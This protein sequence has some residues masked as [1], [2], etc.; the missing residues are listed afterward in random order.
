[1]PRAGWSSRSRSLSSRREWCGRVLRQLVVP[2]L[3]PSLPPSLFSPHSLSPTLSSLVEAAAAGAG[4]STAST[5]AH[6]PRLPVWLGSAQWLA[7]CA[8]SPH[9][10]DRGPRRRTTPCTESVARPKVMCARPCPS[11]PP[12]PLPDSLLLLLPRVHAAAAASF[13]NAAGSA[14]FC[15]YCSPPGPAGAGTPDPA[16][17]PWPV[18][19]LHA[20]MWSVASWRRCRGRARRHQKK[21]ELVERGAGTLCP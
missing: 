15:R 1:M 4:Q 9:F 11:S 12:I 5:H 7:T 14:S 21:T 3:S 19:W 2:S 20:R 6:R 18:R 16:G 17:A 10:A 13:E 8:L